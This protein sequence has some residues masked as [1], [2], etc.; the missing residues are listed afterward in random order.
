MRRQRLRRGRRRFAADMGVDRDAALRQAEKLLRQGKLQGAIEEYVRLVEDQ[1]RDW[2]SLNAL[3]DLYARAGQPDRAVEHYLRVADHLFDEGF[4]PKASALYKKALKTRADDEHTVLRLAEIAAHQGLFSDARTYLRQL[5]KQRRDRGDERGA[6]ECL[7]RLGSL[8]DADAESQ[9]AAAG[10]AES[11]GDGAGAARLYNNAA[12]R[13]D[14]L[15]RADEALDAMVQAA[16]LDPSDH[17]LKGSLARRCILL[18][19]PDRVRGFLSREDAGDDPDLLLIVGRIDLADGREQD[20]RVVLTRLLTIAPD[21]RV[22]VTQ[23]AEEMALAGQAGAAYGCIELVVDDAVLNGDWD[24]AIGALQSFVARTPFVPALMKLVEIAVDADRDPALRQAQALLAD[25]YIETGQ[26]ED[27]RVIAEDLVAFDPSSDANVQRLRRAL[28]LVGAPDA[29]E[30]IARYREPIETFEELGAEPG[31]PLTGEPERSPLSVPDVDVRLEEPVEEE[32]SGALLETGVFEDGSP[33]GHMAETSALGDHNETDL[34]EVLASL[35][36]AAGV[37]QQPQ[38]QPMPD[39]PATDQPPTVQPATDEPAKAVVA[40]APGLEAVFD[41][42][43]A[44]AM[45]EQQVAAALEHFDRGVKHLESGRD[46][47]AIADLQVAAGT[48]ML[49]FAAAARLGRLFLTRGEVE[50]AIEWLERAAEAPPADAD[51]GRAVLYELAAALQTIGECDRA[52]AVLMEIE[53]DAAAYRDVPQRIEQLKTAGD[54][55]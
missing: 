10:A 27:A 3:G 49:R 25:V 18:G 43:R 34:S 19:Q 22:A 42:M 9:V 12:A 36:A 26:A 29:D 35:T 23:L 6:L 46:A 15:G 55:R 40:P 32:P 5:A 21:R 37:A 50:P 52:L 39:R 2:S 7:V 54:R 16:R 11:L 47:E 33:D 53:A 20:A 24:G 8:E 38:R 41:G 30:I 1:P 13:F 51:D 17:A 14:K 31:V 28:E 44:R 45:R 48:P 4:L